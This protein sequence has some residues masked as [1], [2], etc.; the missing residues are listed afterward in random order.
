MGA[1]VLVPTGQEFQEEVRRKTARKPSSLAGTKF[2]VGVLQEEWNRAFHEDLQWLRPADLYAPGPKEREAMR[3]FTAELRAQ[4]STLDAHVK[5]AD[6]Q[7]E[8]ARLQARW[9]GAPCAAFGGQ[10]PL[11]AIWEERRARTSHPGQVRKYE[12]KQ[13]SHMFTE[14]RNLQ[15][16]GDRAGA[17]AQVEL[18]LDLDPGNPFALRLRQKLGACG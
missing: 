9:M 6:L 18:I 4:E 15:E 11:V 17:R 10:R 14:A 5:P 7:E 3:L 1:W 8:L 13:V 12:R 2:N 16:A